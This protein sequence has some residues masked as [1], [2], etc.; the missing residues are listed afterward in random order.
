M[1]LTALISEEFLKSVISTQIMQP[2]MQVHKI[3]FK[4]HPK[5]DYTGLLFTCVN[6][7]ISQLRCHNWG[8]VVSNYNSQFYLKIYV[9]SYQKEPIRKINF[10]VFVF[11]FA[12]FCFCFISLFACLIGCLFVCLFL[13][14]FKIKT[15]S[16]EAPF[17]TSNNKNI[18]VS[19]YIFLITSND[20]K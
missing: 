2:C 3:P 8:H 13:S 20:T 18:F 10:F 12:L 15:D 17:F 14:R 6:V 5:Y 16:I 9:S 11:V 4:C 7:M 1:H 19:Y